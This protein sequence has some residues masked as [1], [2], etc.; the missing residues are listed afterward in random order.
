MHTS[1]AERGDV[2]TETQ[3][4]ACWRT[5]SQKTR[6]G[7]FFLHIPK[8]GSPQPSP[9]QTSVTAKRGSATFLLSTVF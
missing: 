4:P 5:A 9:K 6:T 1:R 8:T 2:V 3:L 7:C